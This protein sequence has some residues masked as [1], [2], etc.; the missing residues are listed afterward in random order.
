VYKGHVYMQAAGCWGDGASVGG[1]NNSEYLKTF[2][3]MVTTL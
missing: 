3:Y 2:H 1:G